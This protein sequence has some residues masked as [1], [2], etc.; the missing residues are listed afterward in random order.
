[1]SKRFSHKALLRILLQSDQTMVIGVIIEAEGYLNVHP[2]KELDNVV[3]LILMNFDA[4]IPDWISMYLKKYFPKYW[5]LLGLYFAASIDKYLKLLPG[6]SLDLD[7]EKIGSGLKEPE[8][9]LAALQEKYDLL[10][11]NNILLFKEKVILQDQYDFLVKDFKGYRQKYPTIESL[12]KEPS[13]LQVEINTAIRVLEEILIK[14]QNRT[15]VYSQNRKQNA[16]YVHGIGFAL[17]K[18]SGMLI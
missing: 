10:Q 7:D 11:E 4:L 8:S 2:K 15:L 14:Y 1:M 16:A 17:Y 5:T 6:Q 13:T 9:K 12:T 18:F 3:D